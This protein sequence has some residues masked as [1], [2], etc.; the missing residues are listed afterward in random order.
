MTVR[1]RLEERYG[2]EY[3]ELL[4]RYRKQPELSLAEIANRFGISRQ[5]VHQHFRSL[6][7]RASVDRAAKIRARALRKGKDEEPPL[8]RRYPEVKLLQEKGAV[9]KRVKTVPGRPYLFKDDRG[10]LYLVRRTTRQ[11]QHDKE[12]SRLRFDRLKHLLD[13]VDYV[14]VLDGDQAYRIPAHLFP[15]SNMPLFDQEYFCKYRIG[16]CKV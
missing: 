12:Y 14:L 2:S 15:K 5:A 9:S 16:S 3:V 13:E 11:R 7:P 6:F 1:K 8:F 10:R 4:E